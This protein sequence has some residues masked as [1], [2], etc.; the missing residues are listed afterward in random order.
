MTIAQI[1][2]LIV[3]LLVAGFGGFLILKKSKS[4]DLLKWLGLFFFVAVI[5]SWIFN[6]G[7]FAGA[8][9]QTITEETKPIGFTDLYTIL[10]YGVQSV[11]AKAMFIIAVGAFYGVLSKT[12]SYS[13]LVNT[14][15][16]KIKGKEILFSLIAS[17]LFVA[18]GSILTQ[19]LV[20]LVFVPFI[21]SILLNAKLDKITAFSVTIGSML[22][23]LLGAT[24]GF[25]GVGEFNYYLAMY[26][27]GKVELNLLIQLLIVLVAYLLF[28]FFNI[29]HIKKVL[30]D[31]V[32]ESEEDPFMVEKADKKASLIPSIVVL[33]LIFVLV[34]LGYVG[35]DSSFGIKCFTKFHEWLTGLTIGNYAV[36]AKIFG[37]SSLAFGAWD[38][39]ILPIILFLFALLVMLMDKMSFN[40]LLTNMGKGNKVMLMPVLLVIGVQSM[41]YIANFSPTIPV[42]INA[43]IDGIKSFNPYIVSFVALIGSIFQPDLGFNA[44][45]LGGYYAATYADNVSLIETIFVSVY[46]LVGLAIPTNALLLAGL[47]YLNIDY[48]SWMKYI[49][50]F[51]LALIVL[52]LVLFTVL[53]YV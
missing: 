41:I 48:K 17:L 40:D 14:I 8:N 12:K 45:T 39:T 6:G 34:I 3:L 23:G 43:I 20:A 35:W 37:T 25:E 27:G 16:K 22:I 51:I 26:T 44:L 42:I 50:I 47:S 19:S 52:L 28:S 49:W 4:Y 46:G 33:S 9:F 13:K 30:K 1:I 7:Y 29:K 53:A 10:S 24:Y 2:G 32:N 18:M 31:K 36:F 15:A 21:V 38:L 11:F 5:F